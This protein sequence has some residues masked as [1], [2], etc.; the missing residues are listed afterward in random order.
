MAAKTELGKRTSIVTPVFRLAFPRVFEPT[1][2]R[3]NLA[4]FQPKYEIT[5]LF[6]KA[7]NKVAGEIM[8]A[9]GVDPELIKGT[10]D[11]SELRRIMSEAARASKWADKLVAKD[12]SP[13]EVARVKKFKSELKLAIRDADAEGKET[14]GYAGHFFIKASNKNKIPIVEAHKLPNGQSIPVTDTSQVYGGMYCRA[15]I[16]AYA[17]DNVS[18]GVSFGLQAL[19]LVRNGTPFTGLADPDKAFSALEAAEGG[20]DDPAQY[21]GA[22]DDAFAEV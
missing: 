13:A 1:T 18:K 11:I 9:A 4:N 22:T 2:N 16:N 7:D 8:A 10:Y 21:A 17:Y 20:K 3:N 14:A 15:L 6:P 5:M 12:Q 19:Q